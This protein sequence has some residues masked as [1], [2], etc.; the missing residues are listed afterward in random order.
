MSNSDNP[1]TKRMITTRDAAKI[2]TCTQSHVIK[3]IKRGKIEASKLFG[4]QGSR[5]EVDYDS[6]ERYRAYRD[7][8]YPNATMCGNYRNRMS[9]SRKARAVKKKQQSNNAAPQRRSDAD[10]NAGD[11]FLLRN[12]QGT[13]EILICGG[14]ARV[15]LLKPTASLD[16]V[17]NLVKQAE[18]LL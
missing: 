6:V 7:K 18:R 3:L 2:L 9:A 1:R 15:K 10:D 14:D 4:T 16:D 11:S 17:S 12:P 13:V 5:Y 8:H